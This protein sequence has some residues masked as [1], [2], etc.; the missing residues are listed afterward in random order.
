ME[1]RYQEPPEKHNGQKW[2]GHEIHVKVVP[3]RKTELFEFVEKIAGEKGTGF[4]VVDINH[5]WSFKRIEDVVIRFVDKNSALLF[6]LTWDPCP[7]PE[8]IF[9]QL[10]KIMAQFPPITNHTAIMSRRYPT[11]DQYADIYPTSVDP[12]VW[13]KDY[14]EHQKTY[15][16]KSR[17]I[18]AGDTI[19]DFSELRKRLDGGTES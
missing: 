19:M 2:F 1:Y 16:T 5:K 14:K 18:K 8:D 17:R 7:E 3:A 4:R 12:I 6:K 10:K 15:W 11:I 9:E 13:Y